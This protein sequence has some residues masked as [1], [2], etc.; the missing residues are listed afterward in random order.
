[1]GLFAHFNGFHGRIS[2]CRLQKIEKLLLV[3]IDVQ[4]DLEVVI[5]LRQRLVNLKHR[6]E[7][8]M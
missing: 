7:E 6:V 3:V 8:K 1:M 5:L 4:F 2:V